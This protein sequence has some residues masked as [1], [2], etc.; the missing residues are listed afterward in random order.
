MA[1]GLAA[2]AGIIALHWRLVQVVGG[3]NT[4]RSSANR[5]I[6]L[7]AAAFGVV[8]A[9]QFGMQRAMTRFEADSLSDLRASL[10]PATAILAL[11]HLPVGSGLGSFEQL[12]SISEADAELFSG[13]A[14]RAHNDWAEF[15][16][17]TGLPGVV[18]ASLFLIWL[19][20]RTIAVWKKHPA[21]VD[22]CAFMLARGG[23]LIIFLLL[24]HSLV[25]YPLRTTALSSLLA[26]AA[27]LLVVSPLFDN[28]S[29]L[30]RSI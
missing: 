24:V 27:A 11:Q 4:S 23:S 21:L 20:R 3:V 9:I 8:F 16:L 28:N 2:T 29:A 13:Y 18:V 1:L 7:A 22:G 30:S 10:S 26:F 25:D 14:N 15:L 5:R 19:T 6:F 12:Y 17:E